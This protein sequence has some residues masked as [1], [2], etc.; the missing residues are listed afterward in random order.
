MPN[1]RLV[2]PDELSGECVLLPIPC[3]LIP[4]VGGLF[5]RWEWKATWRDDLSY[6]L[7]QQMALDLQEELIMATCTNA[8]VAAIERLERS[9]LA[10]QELCCL[11]ASGMP[12]DDEVPSDV[13]Y[14]EGDPPGGMSDWDEWR[15]FVCLSAQDAVDVTAEGLAELMEFVGGAIPVGVTWLAFTFAPETLGAST[16]FA[17]VVEITALL[18]EAAVDELS[19]EWIALKHDMVCAIVNAVTVEGAKSALDAVFDETGLTAAAKAIFK[20]LWSFARLNE[21]FDGVYEPGGGYSTAYCDDCPSCT[22][23]SIDWIWGSGDFENGGL[24]RSEETDKDHRLQVRWCCQ[25]RRLRFHD[26]IGH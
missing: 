3:E 24:L 21:I 23:A 25:P 22:P 15:D 19:D 16:L 13:A 2:Y 4:H 14:G 11:T 1:Q 6:Q 7:G 12:W 9:V 8:I 26:M 18:A 10:T 20:L 17:L 5:E